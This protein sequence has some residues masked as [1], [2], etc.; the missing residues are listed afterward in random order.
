[1]P[2]RIPKRPVRA[3]KD[4][5]P[6]TTPDWALVERAYGYPLPETARQLILDWTRVY[7]AQ[8]AAEQGGLPVAGMKQRLG[9]TLT[10]ADGLAKALTGE[11]DFLPPYCIE[12]V[13]ADDGKPKEIVVFDLDHSIR[14]LVVLRDGLRR[15]LAK[16]EVMHQHKEGEAWAAWV[17]ELTAIC[18]DHKLPTHARQ[19][20][21]TAQEK[22]SPFVRLIDVLERQLNQ[23]RRRASLLALASAINRARSK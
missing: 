14:E 16:L 20:N 13:R 11:D 22:P 4:P 18:E 6:V 1:M 2:R 9:H 17:R 10:A 5:A 19:D 21:D 3:V 23:P 8:R 7:I 12:R 15:V